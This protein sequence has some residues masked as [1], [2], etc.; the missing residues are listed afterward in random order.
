M[1]NPDRTQPAE[2]T[3]ATESK[4]IPERKPGRS[5]TDPQRPLGEEII[6]HADPFGGDEDEGLYG[7]A[8]DHP[9]L[10]HGVAESA[11]CVAVLRKAEELMAAGNPSGETE[12]GRRRALELA[13]G[14]CGVKIDEY[15]YLV[16]TYED[17]KALHRKVMEAARLRAMK[18]GSFGRDW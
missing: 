6:E 16:E 14:R 4:S 15:D 10:G 8:E 2:S 13:C 12:E 5:F 9:R 7:R 17:L 11:R 1:S 3:P 18:I